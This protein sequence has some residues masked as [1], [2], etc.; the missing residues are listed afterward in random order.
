MTAEAR[1]G[2]YRIRL[3]TDN[4]F[5]A[6]ATT[7]SSTTRES[8]QTKVVSPLNEQHTMFEENSRA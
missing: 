7:I 1:R 2:L 5:P 6:S 3:N 8:K 4:E